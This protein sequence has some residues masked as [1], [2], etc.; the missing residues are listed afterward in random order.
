M[1]GGKYHVEF[2]DH[3]VYSKRLPGH[4]ATG[5]PNFFDEVVE[6]ES[7]YFQKF[8]MLPSKPQKPQCH[9]GKEEALREDPRSVS[10]E[11]DCSSSTRHYG[12]SY[13]LPRKI[14]AKAAIFLLDTGCTENLLS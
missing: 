6:E 1:Q 4:S 2:R 7:A 14:S 10:A 8:S 9:E 3:K 11:T 12:T 13:F 5:S